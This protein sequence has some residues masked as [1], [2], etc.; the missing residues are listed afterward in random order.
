MPIENPVIRGFNPDPSIC[1]VGDDYYIATSTFEWFPGVQIHQSR[2]LANWILVGQ[3]LDR[4]SQ[5]DMRGNPDSCG[6]W[7]PALSYNNGL[8][9][10]A[11]TNV[12]RF[13]GNYKD[14]PNY[15][16]TASSIDGPWSNPVYLNASGFDP[17]LFHDTDGKQWLVNMVWDH[18]ATM[19]HREAGR[20]LKNWWDLCTESF[21][22]PSLATQ[23]RH[24]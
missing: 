20:R 12:R 6:V 2:D 8:F 15:L 1:R 11:Y 24:T 10:L 17:S 21:I 7:A 5:L 22:A 23:K 14:T 16:V 4:A 18:R 3:V 9:W 19:E 13:D